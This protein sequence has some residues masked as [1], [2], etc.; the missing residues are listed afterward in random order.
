MPTEKRHGWGLIG[1]GRFAREFAEELATHDRAD[2]VAVASRSAER[3]ATF[4]KEFGFK[5][6]YDS[7]EALVADPDVEIVYVVVPH[8]FHAEIVQLAIEAGKAALCEKPLTPSLPETESLTS[9]AREHGVFLMEAMKTAF[10][11]AILTAKRWIAEGAVGE[12]RLARAD[13]CFRGSTDPEDRLMNPNLGGGCVLDVGIYPLFLTRFLLGEVESL[14]ANGHLA[15]TGVE[16]T[17]AI[18]ARHAKG[19]CSAMTASFRTDDAMDAEILGTEGRI[20][21]PRFHAG[22]SADLIGENGYGEYFHDAQGGMVR[23]EIEAVMDS[24]D[25]GEIECP[26][27]SHADS[28]RLAALMDEVIAQVRSPGKLNETD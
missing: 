28:C 23:A 26:G 11:P 16:D 20:R 17:V 8:V 1:P 10:L 12:P 3:A 2:C 13:F 7:Y 25:R 15:S 14:S 21:L 4:A 5:R 6:S 9:L 24:I 18:S 27:H 22:D 19:A